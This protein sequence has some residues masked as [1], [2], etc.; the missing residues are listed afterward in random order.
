MR[1]RSRLIT[2]LVLLLVFVGG[3]IPACLPTSDSSVPHDQ[4]H[5]LLL[6]ISS[7]VRLTGE[8]D[9]GSYSSNQSSLTKLA[10]LRPLVAPATT[11]ELDILL[12]LYS[13]YM[14]RLQAKGNLTDRHVDT[15]VNQLQRKINNLNK[16]SEQLEKRR[17]RRRRG[18]AGFFRRVGRAIG[19]F[20]RQLG[21]AIGKAAEYLIEE[22]APEVIRDMVLTG[23]PLSAKVFWKGVRKVVRSRLKRAVGL[24][25]AKRGVPPEILAEAGLDLELEEEQEPVTEDQPTSPEI[26]YGNHT[27]DVQNSEGNWGY[28]TWKA[29]WTDLPETF[30]HRC[31]RTTLPIVD[32]DAYL[33]DYTLTFDFDLDAGTLN[34]STDGEGEED[35]NYDIT[36]WTYAL[37]LEEGW[38]KP[39]LDATGW[40]FGGTVVFDVTLHDQWQ[41][42]HCIPDGEGYCLDVQE[43]WLEDEKTTS[44]RAKLEGWTEQVVPGEG[45]EPDR[46]GPGGTYSF[47]IFYEDANAELGLDCE[48]CILPA[49]FP[50]PVYLEE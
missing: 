41:C 23:Q 26:G 5:A 38:V 24:N 21:R 10:Y 36:A 27:V 50:A 32:V 15:L 17:S 25:L 9:L 39:S 4:E 22:V 34:S 2:N 16:R 44:V 30:E 14:S 42:L 3:F 18:L 47:L 48:N 20:V 31:Q 28:F 29:Y 35:S 6:Q 46:L 13:T 49:D 1:I 33:D 12:G 7:H 43:Y 45:D 40:S 37:K 19:R 11:T 8:P